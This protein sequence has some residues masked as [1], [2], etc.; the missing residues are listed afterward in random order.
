MRTTINVGLYDGNSN[1]PSVS[2]YA[3]S[4][5]NLTADALEN[6]ANRFAMTHIGSEI[7]LYMDELTEDA[8]RIL[9]GCII[10]NIPLVFYLR[11]SKGEYQSQKML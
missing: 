10:W 5:K 7:H 2:E 4:R 3:F 11:N 1:Y 6:A 9:S 8:M